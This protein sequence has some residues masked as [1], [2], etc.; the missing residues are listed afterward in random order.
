LFDT[1]LDVILGRSPVPSE[2][3]APCYKE[4]DSDAAFLSVGDPFRIKTASVESVEAAVVAKALGVGVV[5]DC[6]QNQSPVLK[7]LP[8]FHQLPPE[9][10]FTAR[11]NCSIT[12][13]AIGR[14]RVQRVVSV[15]TCKQKAAV[16]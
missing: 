10:H 1:S 6:T 11:A 2:N 8:D 7:R 13:S 3:F 5:P 9:N 16:R 15:T 14:G 12:A 4:N